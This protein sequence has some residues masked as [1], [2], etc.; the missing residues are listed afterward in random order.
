MASVNQL[1]A[2]EVNNGM[3]K[4]VSVMKASIGMELFVY[5]VLTGKSGMKMLRLVSVK[6]TTNGMETS[7]RRK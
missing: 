4:P 7:A 6:L 5:F 1:D 3:E 2:L